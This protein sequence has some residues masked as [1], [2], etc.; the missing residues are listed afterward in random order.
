MLR[1]RNYVWLITWCSCTL[2]WRIHMPTASV[3]SHY[4]QV[5]WNLSI[6]N[7][8]GDSVLSRHSET[9]SGSWL[10]L[11]WCVSACT[12]LPEPV[13]ISHTTSYSKISQSLERT[14]EMGHQWLYCFEIWQTTRQQC[15]RGVCQISEQQLENWWYPSRV[16]ETFRDL[17]TRCLMAYYNWLLWSIPACNRVYNMKTYL[18]KSW[19]QFIEC[20][21]CLSI[22][23][24]YLS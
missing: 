9:G 2:L 1:I 6:W 5:H 8:I 18:P 11:K 7:N 21:F 22:K 14:W 24:I 19:D 17:M 20:L 23:I 3:G 16:L 15:C 10:W 4:L 12:K 13:S